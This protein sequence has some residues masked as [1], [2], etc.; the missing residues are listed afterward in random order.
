VSTALSITV[1]DVPVTP[2]GAGAIA[3]AVQA[4]VAAVCRSFGVPCE[5]DSAVEAGSD[6]RAHGSPRIFVDG[7]RVRYPAELLE[8][9]ASYVCGRYVA[10]SEFPGDAVHDVPAIV[11]VLCRGVILRDAAVLAR[12]APVAGF[13]ER[14]SDVGWTESERSSRELPA[15]VRSVLAER[16][17]LVAVDRVRELLARRAHES[18]LRVAEDLISELR[19]DVVEMSARQDL[20]RAMTQASDASEHLA[21]LGAVA[22]QDLG[23]PLPPLRLVVDPSAK[24]GSFTFTVNSIPSVPW[25][26]VPTGTQAFADPLD[27][28]AE[29]GLARLQLPNPHGGNPLTVLGG[30]E[31]E[32]AQAAGYSGTTTAAHIAACGRVI[33]R[34]NAHLLMDRR[35]LDERLVAYAEAFPSLV[36]AVDQLIDRDFILAVCRKLL[37]ERMSVQ[38]L[39]LILERLVDARGSGIHADDLE[40]TVTFV[41]AGMQRHILRRVGGGTPDRRVVTTYLVDPA[42]EREA[43]L[44]HRN[45]SNGT[46]GVAADAQRDA[47]LAAFK[48]ELGLLPSRLAPPVVVVSPW[49]RIAMRDILATELPRL[50]V[51]ARGEL[52][53]NANVQPIA[54]VVRAG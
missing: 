31:A 16:I 50:H 40:A 15:I 39:S 7:L 23:V 8:R 24:A 11:A 1:T 32:A 10:A 5:V 14:L 41:R 34:S 52:P 17:S 25:L 47:I 19:P 45:K 6:E 51:V 9:S 37:R 29:Y 49:A 43:V 4:E 53:P 27:D 48:R 18:W 13:I 12:D 36:G 20:M 3:E 28:L 33:L 54:R 21:T 46:D 35:V 22:V 42:L 26:A 30:T 38:D 2:S 44:N